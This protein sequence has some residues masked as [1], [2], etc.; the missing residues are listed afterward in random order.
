M[1]EYEESELALS[2]HYDKPITNFN[3]NFKM[4]NTK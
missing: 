3:T 2:T 1:E 4:K